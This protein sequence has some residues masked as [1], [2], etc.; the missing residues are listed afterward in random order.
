MKKYQWG[1]LSTA[2]IGKHA[3]IPAL[4]ASKFAEVIAVASR[5][6]VRARAFADE[7]DIPQAYGGY[8][9][10]LDDAA[11]EA[12]YIPLPNHLHKEW[13]IR[14]A[15]AG[16]HIL[17]EKP[18]ALNPEECREMIAAAEANRVQLMESFMYRYHPR[19]LAARELVRSGVI[20]DLKTI[21]SAFTFRLKNQDN[22]RYK[23]EMGGG[24]LMDVGCYC[25]NISRLMAGREP[26]IVSAR[27]Q[28]ASTGV[29][30]QLTAILDFGDGTIAHF[31]CALNMERRER[32]IVAG[33]D[34]YLALPRCFLPGTQA[35]LIQEVKGRDGTQVHSFE[36]VDEYRLIA[37]EFMDSIDSGSPSFPIH[38]AVENMRVIQALLASA[39]QG[40]HPVQ[41]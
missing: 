9:A 13:T 31:D 26:I 23:P 25:V 11:V 21:E 19:I 28:W 18:L 30:E 16:K 6:P 7:L 14:A 4:K 34:G 5:D 32:C 33:T 29:D 3:M 38:D 8:Q 22:I 20:G 1:I 15:E 36:G 39:K 35:A 17:C 10:L 12:V 40:G 41:L 27:A 37:D 24:A 2:N